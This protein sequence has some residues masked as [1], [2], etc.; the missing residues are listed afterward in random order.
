M[1]GSLA[2]AVMIDSLDVAD[3]R[4]ADV[5]RADVVAFLQISSP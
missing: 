3:V 4:S 5:R 1:I 2:V